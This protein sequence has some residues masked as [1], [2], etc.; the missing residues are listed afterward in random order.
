MTAVH[1]SSAAEHV[2]LLDQHEA[3]VSLVKGR[4]VHAPV[5]APRNVLEVGCGTGVVTRY[6]AARFPTA[7]SVQG[8]DLCP[9]PTDPSDSSSNNLSFIQGNF[10]TLAG[11]D[12]RLGYGTMDL[13]YSRLLLCG[14]TDWPGY[15][16][17]MYAMLKPNGWADFGDFVEDVFYANAE[18][19]QPRDDW[20]WLRAIRAGGLRK[21]LDL[22]CGHNIEG[23][24]RE[25][26]F[27]DI[28]KWEYKVPL[29]REGI[30]EEERRLAEHLTDDRWGLYWHMLP[31]ML[32]GM[33]YD[34][35]AIG[36]LRGEMKK[37]M[38]AEE[39]KWEVFTVTVG[40]KPA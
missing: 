21:G 9:V 19:G 31:R 1:L 25:V 6:L 34:D 33:G 28:E 39:G 32:E 11:A 14:M 22:D 20:E 7:T 15:V 38:R 29:W 18:R 30:K 10:R 36:R 27:V 2:R 37:D 3:L 4:I 12:P 5:T 17:T 40:K 8:I 35:E 16:R 23:Y 26:G 24:M 13:V